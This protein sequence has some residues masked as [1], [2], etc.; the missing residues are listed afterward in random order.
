MPGAR[1]FVSSGAAATTSAE[2]DGD[3]RFTLQPLGEGRATVRVA[4]DGFRAD[5]V[6]MDSTATPRDVGTMTLKVSA[7]SESIVVSANQVEVPLTR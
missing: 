1:V 4:L 7:I 6:T 2:T 5:S 3:G